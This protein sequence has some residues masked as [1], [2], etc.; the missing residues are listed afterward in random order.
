M[1]DATL[2]VEAKAESRHAVI[3]QQIAESFEIRKA[4]HRGSDPSIASPKQ[5]YLDDGEWSARV[6]GSMTFELEES[7]AGDDRSGPVP[8]FALEEDPDDSFAAFVKRELKSGRRVVV[9]AGS[10]N[11]LSHLRRLVRG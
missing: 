8:N 7:G 11:L 5:L 6:A 3:M 4:V 10:D 2:I 9:T 1:P